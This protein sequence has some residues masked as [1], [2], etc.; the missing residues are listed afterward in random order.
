MRRRT[1]RAADTDPQLITIPPARR[2]WRPI[3]A[4]TVLGLVAAV[5]VVWGGRADDPARL[6]AESAT[7]TGE[8]RGVTYRGSVADPDGITTAVQMTV[9]GDGAAH[10]TLA[11]EFG[12]EA[13]IAVDP[14]GTVFT[15]NR[16][17]WFTDQ[18]AGAE[19]LAGAWV[20]NP[21]TE[22]T[23]LPSGLPLTPSALADELSRTGEQPWTEIGRET[24]AGRE[25]LL[26]SDGTRQVV[27][28]T[29]TPR[30][31]LSVSLPQ[32]GPPQV[33]PRA[34]IA[35]PT[36]QP[37]P[38][39]QSEPSPPPQYV[40]NFT[41]DEPTGPDHEA[42]KAVA[43]GIR[44]ANPGR[45]A[46]RPLGEL[47][48]QGAG[49]DAETVELVNRLA[50]RGIDATAALPVPPPYG[51]AILQ[52]LDVITADL[53][54]NDPKRGEEVHLAVKGIGKAVENRQFAGLHEAA[55]DGNLLNPEALRNL[56]Q[57]I[58]SPDT[59]VHLQ[60]VARLTA[61]GNKLRIEVPYYR[62]LDNIGSVDWVIDQPAEAGAPGSN[63][64]HKRI[65]GNHRRVRANTKDAAAQLLRFNQSGQA[66][67]GSENHI[68]LHIPIGATTDMGRLGAKELRERLRQLN[69]YQAC[70][71]GGGGQCSVDRITVTTQ[72]TYEG[73]PVVIPHVYRPEELRPDPPSGGSAGTPNGPPP[74][75]AP[76]SGAGAPGRT[77]LFAGQEGTVEGQGALHNAAA[78]QQASSLGGIDFSSL[79]LRY[80][81]ERDIDDGRSMRYAF[82]A[83]P[84]TGAPTADAAAGVGAA[85]QASDAFFVWLALPTSAFTVNLNPDE[86]DRIVDPGLGRTDAGRILLEADL[87]LKKTVAGLI[88]PETPLGV[89]YWDTISRA[90]EQTCQSFRQW[91]VPAPAQVWD[92]GE[93]M[94]ILDAPLQVKMETEYLKAAGV[95]VARSAC[96]QQSQAVEDQNENAFRTMILPE[97]ERAVNEAP[98]YADLRQVY[99][100]RVAAEWYRQRSL[101]E[102][103]SF[104]HLIDKG[105][106]TA[107]PAR[108]EWSPRAVFD[109]YVESFTKGE[110][111]VSRQTRTGDYIETRTYV[112]GGVDWTQVSL[113]QPSPDQLQSRWPDLS[114]TVGDSFAGPT[115]GRDGQIWLSSASS[116][117]SPAD[118]NGSQLGTYL[119]IAV[120]AIGAAFGARSWWRVRR[121]NRNWSAAR[122]HS[123]R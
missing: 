29:E 7:A 105:D 20:N 123:P 122:A 50:E 1:R 48:Q 87:Q 104:T 21:P 79:E 11:R 95:S 65:S 45:P 44:A 110:F 73:R 103:M 119:A 37:Q 46:P 4:A 102:H 27:V 74:N 72:S 98:E 99:L 62:Q 75:P 67:P 101:T 84:L 112:Y 32:R 88:H 61:A 71:D 68:E 80:L 82:A 109:R 63:T 17:W 14:A 94:Y 5:A 19:T 70:V 10:G 2:R 85:Q 96:P 59:Q 108:E 60:A 69:L 47:L 36:D 24:V 34:F 15:G 51:K 40:E 64:E 41:I 33:A 76:D 93:E 114:A 116:V 31:L 118:E 107:W 120:I 25:G 92:N 91:I 22:V 49:V 106:V 18:P 97:V 35:Q 52:V 26:L 43:E 55:T 115:P 23:G 6:V 86:P 28:S 54:P 77:P 100:S 12:A 90:G 42:T 38:P 3:A 121:A 16:E 111:N 56:L 8:W 113:Q 58:Q 89:R 9:T 30:R 83:D 81:A 57:H 117:P 13:E 78:Q 66:R 53:A 39:D